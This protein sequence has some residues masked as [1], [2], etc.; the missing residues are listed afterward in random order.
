[1][2]SS[3]KIIFVTGFG[4]FENH[5]EK[6]ASWE[7]VKLLPDELTFQNS[8]FEIRKL[9]VPVTYEAVNNAVPQIWKENPCV[10]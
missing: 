6:N 9:E 4:P 5:L 2:S 3:K 1:M 8:S 10:R 7:A